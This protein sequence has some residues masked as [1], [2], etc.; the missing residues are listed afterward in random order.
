MDVSS[1]KP[2]VPEALLLLYSQDSIIVPLVGA[3]LVRFT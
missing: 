1:S 2:L 3:L